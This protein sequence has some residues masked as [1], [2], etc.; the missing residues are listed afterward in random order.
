LNYINSQ[1]LKTQ[2]DKKKTKEKTAKMNDEEYAINEDILQKIKGVN[3]DFG[4]S[5]A[6]TEKFK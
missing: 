2:M 3:N 4:R 1:Y 5:G 6:F